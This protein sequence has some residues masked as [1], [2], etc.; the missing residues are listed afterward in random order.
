VDIQENALLCGFPRK[1]LD[2]ICTILV[3][4]PHCQKMVNKEPQEINGVVD[5]ALPNA[6]FRIT[7]EN[8]E[9]PI[10]GYLS[11]KMRK[12]RIKVLVGD[13]VIVLTDPYGGKGRIIKRL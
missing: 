12:Y 7:L 8:Q 3:L 13:K 5:E 1:K 11:G 10:I 6:L 4:C 9:E 2:F